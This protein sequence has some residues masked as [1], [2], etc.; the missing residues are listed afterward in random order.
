MITREIK[1]G[2]KINMHFG[3]TIIPGILNDSEPA[4]ELI[5]RLP[6]TVRAS[7]YEFDVC[8]V[9]DEP[10]SF[11]DED[12]VPGWKNGDIDFTTQ[13]DYFTIL[14]ANEE[15]CYGEFVN[16]GV[17]DCDPSTMNSLN[18]SFDILIELA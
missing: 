14:F 18:G 3:S 10:L 4:R 12:L 13:G 2:T 5:S 7:R 15:N 8:G 9:M 6:Y 16:L 17:I 11:G 1:N